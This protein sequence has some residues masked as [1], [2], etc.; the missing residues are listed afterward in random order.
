MNKTDLL[1]KIYVLC[2]L[3][4]TLEYRTKVC[5]KNCHTVKTPSCFHS[6]KHRFPL[7][8]GS[9]VREG[10]SAFGAQKGT[11]VLLVPRRILRLYLR[12]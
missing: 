9:V 10:I 12:I 7:F 4:F 8:I 1:G 3:I 2:A 11:T 5:R 6:A